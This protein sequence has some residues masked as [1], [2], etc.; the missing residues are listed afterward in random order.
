MS[1]NFIT[2]AK[3][4]TLKQRLVELIKGSQELKFLVGFFYF[5]GIRELY[6]A[7][8]D[9]PDIKIKILVGLH[10]DRMIRGIV[11][12]PG[13]DK[14]VSDAEQIESFLDSVSKSINIDEFD[15]KE[16]YERIPFFLK[17]IKDNRLIIRKT[18]QPNHAKLYI[19]KLEEAQV[20]DTVFVTGSSNLT[21]TGIVDRDEFNVEIADYGT[22]EAENY[23]DSLWQEAIEI[24][25]SAETKQRLLD[26][27]EK[28]SLV[29]QPT[30]YEA[31]VLVLKTYIES[32][33]Q[34]DVRPSII[35]LMADKGYEQYDYQ[36]DAV[37]QALTVIDHYSGVIIADVVGL[38]K[39]II[40]CMVA[41]S[42]NKR[43][44][45]VCPPGL[46]GDKNNES[47]WRKYRSDFELFDWDVR[48][49]GDLE[50]VEE[51]IKKNP[52]LEVVII[53]ECHRFRNQDT[54]AYEFLSNIC[55]DR[56]VILLTATPFNNSPKDIFSLLKLF[57]IPGKSNIT[58]DDNLEAMFATYRRAF[59]RL[60]YIQK[61]HGSSNSKKQ[62]QAQNYYR[63][64]FGKDN[65][66]LAEVSLRT[67][68][69]ADSIRAVIEPVVIRRNRLDLKK[70]LVYQKEITALPEVQ[71]PEELFF[72]LTPEQS[73]FY[74]TVIN[75]YFSEDGLFKGAI[76]R[77]FIYEE[78]FN[79][80]EDKEGSNLEANRERVTQTNLFDFMRRLLVKRFESSFGSFEQ[81][82]KNF[83]RVTQKVL[84]FIENSKGRYILDRALLERIYESDIDEIDKSLDN[85]AQKLEEGDFPRHYK[86]YHLKDFQ[87]KDQF[88][89]DIQADLD[90]F[91][92]I[93]SELKTLRLVEQDPKLRRLISALK[94]DVGEKKKKGEP[95]RKTIIF[96]E[97]VDTVA[98][99]QKFLD[100]EFQGSVLTIKG[101]LTS[102]K[103]KQLYSNFDAKYEN[104][105]NKY[106]ILLTS[107]K[108]SEGFNLN[109]AGAIINYDIPWNPTRVIQRV[110]R[111]NRIGKKL[112][113]DL[114]IFNFFPSEIGADIV[115]SRQI[116]GNKMFLIH[117]TLG[118]DAKIFDPEETPS[119]SR[120]FKR[121][122]Q[123]PEETEEES[124]LTT[125][126]RLYFQLKKKNPDVLE[127]V[128]KLASRVKVAK[129]YSENQMQVFIRKGSGFFVRL[130]REKE[131]EVHNSSITE[132]LPMIECAPDTKALSLSDRF[133]DAYDQVRL[134]KQPVQKGGG[135]EVRLDRR[136]LNN[137]KTLLKKPPQEFIPLTKFARILQEDIRDFRSLSDFTLR[138]IAKYDTADTKEIKKA[139]KE[140]EAL[141]NEL[142][143]DYLDRIRR[144]VGDMPSEII[145]AIE[146]VNNE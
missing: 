45:I 33:Q 25:E 132:V 47:G 65:I 70:D 140:I 129:A 10:V 66:D 92:Q 145:I 6:D 60:S 135:S 24:T 104:Q 96:S 120:L 103:I 31:F 62:K 78:G 30:P 107:D 99:L 131:D 15:T 19:F 9:K 39:S 11:E 4:K 101:D 3:T 69:L 2:N 53:D 105:E 109:R 97:Y 87:D 38:G 89:K 144:R 141:R 84:T 122:Q 130:W 63:E 143:E 74:D 86:I 75:E 16:F 108:L 34:K 116:A 59:D 113:D 40:A 81:S 43:G 136:A 1:K 22:E 57:V 28:R 72:D 137:L 110:G 76:Y 27:V 50:S 91:N 56:I 54:K 139:I 37:R 67:K 114:Y 118:E 32:Q 64:M 83:R 79:H 71:N 111:I 77:P 117:N 73:Q 95:T 48:S 36:L 42:L 102:T 115:K 26:L 14:D 23:F 13:P 142:G 93:L 8:K 51:Y 133:W 68:Y 5:S 90:L 112:F 94:K 119:P 106:S 124:T 46:I 125:I 35:Q 82:I 29:T 52:D 98:Y 80:G 21:K 134:Y 58:L 146:N 121:I 61:N 44:L 123:N 138:R 41:R 18:F 49:S 55:R 127:R 100:K 88:L 7:I 126:R 128:E 17:L 85:F 20:K 12:Y